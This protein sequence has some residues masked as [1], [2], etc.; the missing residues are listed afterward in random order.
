MSLF[1]VTTTYVLE[2]ESRTEA[3]I[4]AYALAHELTPHE[5][6]VIDAAAMS[7][8]VELTEEE[9][10]EAIRLHRGGKLFTKVDIDFE[11]RFHNERAEATRNR[12]KAGM[13]KGE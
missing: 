6:Q 9:Q 2:A 10:E 8:E 5:F 1:T 12:I 4:K 11:P 3:A 13:E 7:T